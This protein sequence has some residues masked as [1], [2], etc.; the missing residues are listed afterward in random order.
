MFLFLVNFLKK[1][2]KDVPPADRSKVFIAYDNICNI[3]RLKAAKAELPFEKPF[4]E[5][6]TRTGKIIDTFHLKNHKREECHTKYNPK[7]LKDIHPDFNTQCCEQTN[8]WLGKFNR[9]LSSMPKV[10]NNFFVH[11]L[12]KRR[13]HYNEYCYSQ[14]KKPVLPSKKLA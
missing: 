5:I 14:G 9:I 8:S 12:V 10:H 11:R 3:E 2:L 7:Q 6:W 4:D 13:N 1:K